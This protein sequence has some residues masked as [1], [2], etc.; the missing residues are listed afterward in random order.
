MTVFIDA[1]PPI[2]LVYTDDEP[3]EPPPLLRVLLFIII[4]IIY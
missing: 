2:H 1:C 4:I 3:L